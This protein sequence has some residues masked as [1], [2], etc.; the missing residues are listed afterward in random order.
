[1]SLHLYSTEPFL[2]RSLSVSVPFRDWTQDV[3]VTSTNQVHL[4]F[5]PLIL[6]K[7]HSLKRVYGRDVQY[8]VETLSEPLD[9][10]DPF[11]T[12]QTHLFPRPD[13][14]VYRPVT[15]LPSDV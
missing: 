7:I 5:I 11:T 1:M 9:E 13:C 14:V 6:K 8:W 15:T 4:T 10:I 2:V 12:S 3:R